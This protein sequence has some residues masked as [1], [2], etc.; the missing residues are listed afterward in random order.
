MCLHHSLSSVCHSPGPPVHGTHLWV[1][2]EGIVTGD[3]RRHWKNQPHRCSY[4]N[5]SFP[6]TQ[7]L[8]AP[9]E[10]RPDETLGAQSLGTESHTST[11]RM[12]PVAFNSATATSVHIYHVLFY[13]KSSPKDDMFI[14]FQKE[15]Q[16]KGGRREEEKRGGGERYV[17]VATCM[18]PD[19]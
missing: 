19:H 13:I 15:R 8:T 11:N 9:R 18:C 1:L 16:G 12:D 10:N 14:D 4:T 17:R 5:L 7:L 6:T 3:E 2:K